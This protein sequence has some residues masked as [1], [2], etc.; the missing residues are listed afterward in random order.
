MPLANEFETQNILSV[1]QTD[2]MSGKFVLVNDNLGKPYVIPASLFFSAANQAE[3]A[4][5]QAD[6]SAGK[7][8]AAVISANNATTQAN[9]ARDE[10]NA[11]AETANTAAANVKDGKT[12]KLGTVNAASGSVPSGEFTQNGSDASGNPIYILDL[13]VPKGDNGKYPLMEQGTTTTIEPTENA[14]VEIVENGLSSEGNPKYVMNFFIPRGTQGLPGLGSGNVYV[15][16][17]GLAMGKQ[18]LFVPLS[19]G[20]TQGEFVEYVDPNVVI[21]MTGIYSYLASVNPD[22]I[23]LTSE[24]LNEITEALSS[25]KQIVL[26][27][28]ASYADVLYFMNLDYY[29]KDGQTYYFSLSGYVATGSSE[30]LNSAGMGFK[31]SRGISIDM[32]TGVVSNVTDNMVQLNVH[33]A[34]GATQDVVSSYSD[35]A[36]NFPQD[37]LIKNVKAA[38]VDGTDKISVRNPLTANQYCS[39]NNNGLDVFSPSTEANGGISYLD[40]TGK[41]YIGFIGARITGDTLNKLFLG[42]GQDPANSNNQLSVS[43]DEFKYKNVDVA[44]AESTKTLKINNLSDDRYAELSSLGLVFK[45]STTASIA[46]GLYVT[47][48]DRTKILG[49]LGFTTNHNDLTDTNIFFTWGGASDSTPAKSLLLGE[50]IFKY[51]NID[52]ALTDDEKA[53]AVRQS[54]GSTRLSALNFNGIKIIP[55]NSPNNGNGLFWKKQDDSAVIG[56]IGAVTNGDNVAD[57]L[58][59]L[60]WG[61]NIGSAANSLLVGQNTFTYKNIPIPLA[62]GSVP[63]TNSIIMKSGS[64]INSTVT[65]KDDDDTYR[66]YVGKNGGD[67]N[68]AGIWLYNYKTG[69]SIKLLDSGGLT[70][71][72]KNVW[73]DGLTGIVNTAALADKSVT[74]EKLADTSR[75]LSTADRTKLDKVN[76]YATASSIS[77]LDVTKDI[78]YVELAANG[79][80]SANNA[81]AAYNGHSFSVKIYCPAQRVIT[82]PTMGNYVSMCGSSFTCPAGKRV[83]FSFEGVNGQWWI[84]KLEQE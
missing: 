71:N 3:L 52:V 19:D 63:F 60:T 65:F 64:T 29:R 24:T 38:T 37:V 46:Q 20:S 72:N 84:A 70:Y 35:A 8:D 43:K 5:R 58:A 81:G 21:S 67:P 13:V 31:R 79:S 27:D 76:S 83:E 23:T 75:L 49:Q 53:I 82:I 44:L 14:K 28:T 61:G 69:E 77:N 18:Y 45:P 48:G 41:K 6:L 25:G 42:W 4:A 80:L 55:A 57:F 51:K 2:T 11:A 7:A 16:G 78:I 56:G 68:T 12:P 36:F 62:N 34:D 22:I 26:T 73:Y 15:E 59:Y 74:I 39:I 47:N 9:N 1:Q 40:A 50:N 10:A 32:T 17:V 66:G 33:S 54:N 30:A